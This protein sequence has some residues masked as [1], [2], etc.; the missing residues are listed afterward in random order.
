MFHIKQYMG[1]ECPPILPLVEEALDEGFEFLSRLMRDWESGENS[2]DQ[3]G[4][5][6]FLIWNDGVPVGVGGLN[7]D[8][9][10]LDT[11]IGRVRHVYVSRQFRRR[12]MG[13]ALLLELINISQH[14][15]R[16]LRLRTNT[17]QGDSF[18]RELGFVPIVESNDST[19]CLNLTSDVV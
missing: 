17:E 11:C 8:P 5:V 4:E 2:F 14:R 16:M 3:R 12:G 13:R 9:Y 6:L 18:Y 1:A 15:F 19:H 7:V 10:A